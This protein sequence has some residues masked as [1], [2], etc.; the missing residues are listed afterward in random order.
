MN[1]ELLQAHIAAFMQ[2]LGSN[3]SLN[4]EQFEERER[5]VTF[6]KSWTRER[7]LSMNEQDVY[8]YLSP[9]WAMLIWGNKHYI[10]DKIINDNTLDKLKNELASL[11]YD[12][13]DIEIRWNTFRKEIKWIGPAMISE[14]LCH[15]FPTDYMIWNRRAYIGLQYIGVK[16]LPNYDYQLTGKRYKYLSSVCNEIAELL[17]LAGFK[18]PTLLAV[19]YFLWE[20]LQVVE[21][22]TQYRDIIEIVG[23]LEKADNSED[24]A[25][26]EFKHN[27]VRDKLAEIGTWLG[28]NADTEKRVANG[29]VVDTLWEATIG[30]MGR[31]I[32]VFEVQ[33]NGSIDSLLLN[34]LKASNNPAVQGLVAVSDVKQIEKIKK[35]VSQIPML[36]NK[37]KYWDY[38]EVLAVYEQLAYGYSAIN[39]LGLVPQGF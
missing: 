21:T 6:Y 2:K 27:D 32:Y 16:D 3:T 28:F 5:R 15:T 4:N 13:S 23:E 9:L 36:N 8:E 26:S 34:L 7:I 37:L 31:V 38:T 12:K 18:D 19:D 17:K 35:E 14:I 29:A 33:T 1:K 39:R 20:E 10:V 24:K 22:L 25:V 30:N 11:L